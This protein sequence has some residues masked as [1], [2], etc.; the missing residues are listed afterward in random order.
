MPEEGRAP[1]KSRLQGRNPPFSPAGLGRR[2]ELHST[3]ARSSRSQAPGALLQIPT[4]PRVVVPG[5]EAGGDSGSETR[6]SRAGGTRGQ[7]S[8]VGAGAPR[9]GRALY[10]PHP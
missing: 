6:V 9:P 2:R 4:H 8:C 1:F 5:S 3:Q 10:L 7:E